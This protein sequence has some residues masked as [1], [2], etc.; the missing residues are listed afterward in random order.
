MPQLPTAQARNSDE[1]I[2]VEY[3]RWPVRTQAPVMP[4]PELRY[5]V[6][7]ADS[8]EYL[9][10][11]AWQV[12]KLQLRPPS[13]LVGSDRTYARRHVLSMGQPPAS[14]GRKASSRGMVASVS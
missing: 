7:E 9:H 1:P 2:A 10:M 8:E 5:F 11:V 12:V 14:S 6:E 4:K 13:F 3:R